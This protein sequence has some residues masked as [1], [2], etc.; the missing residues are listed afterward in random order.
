MN[1]P[2]F[3]LSIKTFSDQ[4]NDHIKAY[5]GSHTKEE[6]AAMRQAQSAPVEGKITK[7]NTGFWTSAKRGATKIASM[8]LQG[9]LDLAEAG[10]Y[11]YDKTHP[12][13]PAPLTP[14]VE[15]LREPAN[16]GLSKEYE[17]ASSV[18]R[19]LA[20]L[21]QFTP[22][23][24]ASESTG[25]ASLFLQGAGNAAHQVEELK[26]Q[27]AEFKNHSD[28]AHILMS[29]MAN[30][31]LLKGLP[32][33]GV[34]SKL[35]APLRES[36]VGRLSLDALKEVGEKP[37]A[38]AL[39]QTAK[40]VSVKFA[41]RLKSGGIKFLENYAKTAKDLTGLQ[42]ADY[43]SKA[44]SN[45]LSGNENFHQD[46]AQLAEGI[47]RIFTTDAPI[48]A[49]LGSAVEGIKDKGALFRQSQYKNQV[50]ESLRN[51]GDIEQVKKDLQD[52]GAEQGWSEKEI[53]GSI[54]AAEEL[55]QAVKAVPKEFGEA[56]TNKAVD[57]ITG[58]K[59]LEDHLAEI[60]T[61]KEGVDA[62]V[63][64]IP[65][66]EEAMVQAKIDQSNDKLRELASDQKYRYNFDE[67]KG[68]YT[69]Q[70][71]ENGKPEEISKDRY[72]LE[73]LEKEFK[74]PTGPLAKAEDDLSVL[75]QVTDKTKKYEGSM[76]RL[77]DAK[78]ADQ[79]TEK[80]FNEMKGRFDD[81]MKDSEQSVSAS[82]EEIIEPLNIEQNASQIESTTPLGE[83]PIGQ[84]S[85]GETGSQGM[86]SSLE[87][88]E[89]PGKGQA[90]IAQ[91]KKEVEPAATVADASVPADT[92]PAETIYGTKNSVTE[93]LREGMGIEPI[94]LPK[95]RS[96]DASLNGWKE[97][98]RTPKEI[99][100]ELLNPDKDIYDKAITPNDEPIMR[101]YIKNLT[102]QGVE[103]NK[104]KADL[105]DKVSKGDTE[106]E[107]D[108]ASV[109][110]Q[111]LNHYDET[112]RALNASRTAGNIW[113]KVGAERQL[114]I[115]E[116]GLV[117]NS[118]NRIKTLYGDAIPETVKK[119]LSDL[120]QKYDNLAAKN[121]KLE[122]ELSNQG[123]EGVFKK[124]RPKRT[125]FGTKKRSAE[126]YAAERTKILEDLK[127]DL[128][129]SLTNT[130][131]TVPGIPQLNAISP[132]VLKL[133]RSFADQGAGKLDDVI[134]QIH[135]AV[136]DA[137]EGISKEDI[138][139]II[140]GKYSEKKP[141]SEL[142]KKLADLRTEAR[143]RIKIEQLEKGIIAET[144]KRGESNPAVKELQKQLAD[145]R[146]NAV[147]EFAEASVF[148]LKSQQKAIQTQID[149]G[150]FFK[151]PLVKRTWENNPEWQK[152]NREK[153]KLRA[154]LRDM[155]QEAF[156]SKKSWLMRRLDWTNRWGRRVIF[157]MS[158]A[159]YTKLSSAAV[160]GSFLHR[161]IEQGLGKLNSKL[162]P[163]IAKNAPI[164]GS[165]NLKAEAKFYAEF[166]NPK[167]FVKNTWDIAKTGETELSRELSTFKHTNHIPVIDLFAADAHIMIKDPVKRATFEA[168]LYKQLQWYA[169]HGIDGTHPLMLE[170]ARQA[171]YKRAE[172]EIFQNTDNTQ[173]VG[174]FFNALERE[175]VK[176]RNSGLGLGKLEGNAK[177]T[178][179]SL[180]HFFVPIN[181]VPYN[182][183]KRIGLGLRLP[184][185]MVE[186]FSKN[187]DI[188]NGILN[189][190]NEEANTV[191]LQLK[192]GQVAAAY[193]TLGFV[194]G[195]SVGGGLYTKYYPDK[196]RH[197]K[198][199]S[200][201]MKIGD[202]EV[203]K[204]VQ[205]NTQLQAFQMGTTWSIVY[206]KY[207]K[208]KGHSQLKAIAAATA[209]T[210]GA[211]IEQIP[212]VRFG[213]DLYEST[214]DKYGGV[215]FINDLKRRVGVQKGNT[216]LKLMGYGKEEKEKN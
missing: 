132:H 42:V 127:A 18:E 207:I 1:A 15:Q 182:I 156:N 54:Q 55:H 90:E 31:F 33:S 154:R 36:I 93:A 34:L 155:E 84:E 137:V 139:D 213:A 140:V 201:E 184:Y 115:D 79:I 199:R 5:E 160:L 164:E 63:R 17:G 129:K 28:D 204:N 74:K 75:K 123:A 193:W 170:S 166:M 196:K 208:D 146:K 67:E 22:A 59:E 187:K 108:L 214:Q 152:N 116:Q 61:A 46:P 10:T 107:A 195:S 48:F 94:H 69:K 68:K 2:P 49:G 126:E 197:G 78:N 148:D 198:M 62:A 138:R 109:D 96:E 24:L 174:K 176:D 105:Q 169:N 8:A 87:G 89:T 134:S 185:T 40:D 32:I 56:K 189:M 12:L 144:K 179:S 82:A 88:A 141:L 73:Q 181:T 26:K 153:N 3:L 216:I 159:V 130:Y 44:I 118:I 27:G 175:G 71:G 114:S 162:F 98:T 77:T 106:A 91:T 101:E 168:S 192:K 53:A 57:L 211:G 171:A 76:K 157:F 70:L 135:D 186:A 147:N 200:D 97:G 85:L 72:E 161:P 206:G 190:T 86:G 92:P 41:D 163:A 58:R 45:K 133:M 16:L 81:V 9:G 120:Q 173:A 50:V 102:E 37:T 212:S 80:E 203:P 83:Q 38:E 194:L 124:A 95:D 167:S 151:Q 103:L 191:M 178:V 177:Y 7:D 158:N 188:K 25:G 136:K 149:K 110:Q 122:E 165:V 11:M 66:K 128:K 215:K 21:A 104:T 43:A 145:L 99:V 142:N 65:T 30:Y 6:N 131:A 4:L 29:G 119:E 52:H 39:A 35:P 64:E 205:H 19:G 23:V 180:Y 100:E 47:K 20:G 172:Y 13:N 112:E 143:T 121:A 117:L 150:E 210:A 60:Q 202:I 183:L 51:G 209:A 14:A 111:L 125:I 113:H